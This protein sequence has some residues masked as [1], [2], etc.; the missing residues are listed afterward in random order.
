MGRKE[1]GGGGGWEKADGCLVD[2]EWA[3]FGFNTVSDRFTLLASGISVTMPT[4]LED[5]ILLPVI[6]VKYTKMTLVIRCRSCQA[7]DDR[8]MLVAFGF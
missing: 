7:L 3:R 1:D 4:S 2:E 5:A 8:W 6:N